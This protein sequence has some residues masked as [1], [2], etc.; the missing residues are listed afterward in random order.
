MVFRP[1]PLS[2]IAFP[3]ILFVKSH[4]RYLLSFSPSSPPIL[5]FL[6]K[7]HPALWLQDKP[8]FMLNSMLIDKAVEDIRLALLDEY[9]QMRR[10]Q[11]SPH[12]HERHSESTS[13]HIVGAPPCRLTGQ[14][15]SPT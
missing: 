15:V 11:L 14:D 12:E 7:S 6:L 2:Y 8:T 1:Q 4:V 5:H 3:P 10:C 9:L 13:R